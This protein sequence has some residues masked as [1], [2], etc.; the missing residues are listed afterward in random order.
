[1]TASWIEEIEFRN[2]LVFANVDRAIQP[3]GE[4][5][6]HVGLPCVVRT[7]IDIDKAEHIVSASA[8]IVT[9]KARHLILIAADTV[10]LSIGRANQPINSILIERLAKIRD[11]ELIGI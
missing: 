5:G 9:E 6:N 2:P 8:R 4:G 10:Q 7:A 3:A 11:R 1:M